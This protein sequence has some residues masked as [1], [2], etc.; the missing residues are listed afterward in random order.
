M[1]ITSTSRFFHVSEVSVFCCLT[2]SIRPEGCREY[3]HRSLSLGSGRDGSCGGA[4]ISEMDN[5]Q[6]KSKNGGKFLSWGNPHSAE[7]HT[8]SQFKKFLHIHFY[9]IWS[10]KPCF[11]MYTKISHIS[12]RSCQE[13]L[14]GKVPDHDLSNLPKSDIPVWFYEYFWVKSYKFHKKMISSANIF[15]FSSQIRKTGSQWFNSLS[16]ISH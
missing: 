8:H 6:K 4:N 10:Y 9:I 16:K 13:R 5:A 12:Y 14:R 1:S 15:K 2:N 3:M 11:H 7:I